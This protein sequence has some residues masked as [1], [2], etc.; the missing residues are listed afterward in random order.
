MVGK[1]N[2]YVYKIT[3]MPRWQREWIN[4]HRS[5][6]YSGLVQEMLA[7]IIEKHD[8]DYFE[9]NKKHLETKQPRRMETTITFVL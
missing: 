7:R 9:K 4:S 1:P 6:N 3:S 8:P 5:I 2:E